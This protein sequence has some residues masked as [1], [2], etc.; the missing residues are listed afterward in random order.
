MFIT[1]TAF[2]CQ[3]TQTIVVNGATA[4][5][6]EFHKRINICLNIA[7]TGIPIV[8][9]RAYENFCLRWRCRWKAYRA[10]R[11]NLPAFWTGTI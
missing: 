3:S 2:F 1:E 5:K 9:K 4:R 11:T 8:S 10:T 7:I 6:V